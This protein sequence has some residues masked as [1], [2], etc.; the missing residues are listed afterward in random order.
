[1]SPPKTP[2]LLHPSTRRAI[3]RHLMR[4]YEGSKRP[5]PW[6]EDKDAYRVWVSEVMLQQTRVQT[7]VPYYRSFLERFPTVRS[8]AEADLQQVLKAW[9]GLG[10][11]GRARNLHRA[12]SQVM[13]RYGGALPDTT[14][15]LRRLPGVGEYI[16]AAVGSIAFGRAEAVVDGNVKRVLARLFRMEEPVNRP[17]SHPVF[18]NWAEALLDVRN[19]GD[20]NQALMELGALV[21]TPR[22]PRC[23][24]CPLPRWCRAHGAGMTEIYPKRIRSSPVPEV[25]IA[26][27]VVYRKDRMLIT[28]RKPEGLLGGLWEFPGGKIRPGETAA[29]ACV[30]EIAEEVG[31]RVAVSSHLAHVRHAY[32]HFKIR[33]DV[34]QCRYR[35]GKVRLSG[36]VDHRWIL[37]EALDRYPFPGAN[38][39]FLH[40]LREEGR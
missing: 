2:P 39:K 28:Q 33:M 29:Q 25:A 6:R 23:A 26:C 40:L 3:G 17:T 1:M 30:R 9:E 19:P 13:D 35:S 7:V 10:Y 14:E 32:T 38:R 16:A 4:W 15:E 34:F 21:C 22:A 11:Y 12:A 8:L 37:P 36:P 5:L 31:I 24:D 18:R 20:F 27:G